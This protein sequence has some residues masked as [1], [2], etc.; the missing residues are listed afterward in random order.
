[1][2]IA[3]LCSFGH[4]ANSTCSR[5]PFFIERPSFLKQTQSGTLERDR[6][7]DV[8]RVCVSEDGRH[9]APASKSI[10]N[11]VRI[12]SEGAGVEEEGEG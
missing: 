7:Y 10:F 5:S 3:T 2:F 8:L 6:V 11:S 9:F 12:K 1:M 4:A